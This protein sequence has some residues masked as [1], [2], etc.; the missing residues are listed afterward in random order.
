MQSICLKKTYIAE[1]GQVITHSEMNKAN[2][3]C[4]FKCFIS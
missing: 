3:I 1:I 4:E 2:E